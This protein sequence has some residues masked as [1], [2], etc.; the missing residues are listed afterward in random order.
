MTLSAKSFSKT[1]V[2]RVEADIIKTL[3]FNLIFNTAYHFLS[4]FGQILDFEPKKFFL[5]QYVL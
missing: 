1:D 3:D 5:S 4:A 2:L